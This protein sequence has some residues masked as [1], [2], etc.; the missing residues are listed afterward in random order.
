MVNDNKFDVIIIKDIATKAVP[1]CSVR[2]AINEQPG[3]SLVTCNMVS[4]FRHVIDSTDDLHPSQSMLN[5][6]TSGIW[7]FPR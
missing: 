3:F 2:K 7:Q 5:T 6:L 4:I 1:L